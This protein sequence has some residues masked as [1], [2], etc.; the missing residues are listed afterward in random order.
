MAFLLIYV[1]FILNNR[2]LP[3][4][5]A[6][7]PIQSGPGWVLAYTICLPRYTKVL[8][9]VGVGIFVIVILHALDGAS[10]CRTA[11]RWWFRILALHL[12]VSALVARSVCHNTP[13]TNEWLRL[14]AV[15]MKIFC[16]FIRLSIS[17]RS[18]RSR[19]MP[20]Y[21]HPWYLQAALWP[22]YP[23]RSAECRSAPERFYYFKVETSEKRVD[24]SLKHLSHSIPFAPSRFTF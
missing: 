19:P 24:L 22:W 21:S 10:V 6:S 3:G 12:L 9:H 5:Q 14:K 1:L 4:A 17:V 20:A 23:H 13:S 2:F 15:K 7:A 16:I 11:P 18:A 8:I